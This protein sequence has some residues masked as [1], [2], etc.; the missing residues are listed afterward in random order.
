MLQT[1]DSGESTEVPMAT[2]Y[3]KGE[4]Y[5]GLGKEGQ[6]LTNPNN[7]PSKRTDFQ[8]LRIFKKQSSIVGDQEV[9]ALIES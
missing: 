5:A 2:E 1:L 9:S 3:S 6:S 7:P 8:A 4:I